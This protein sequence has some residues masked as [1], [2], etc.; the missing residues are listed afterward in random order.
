VEQIKQILTKYQQDRRILQIN[1]L[2]DEK[3]GVQVGGLVGAQT[4]FI[5][6]ASFTSSPRNYLIIDLDKEEAIYKENDLENILE[7]KDIVFFPDSFKNPMRFDLIEHN[8]VLQRT[9]AINKLSSNR[10]KGEIL[11]TYPEALFEKVVAPKVLD[12]MRIEITVG[13]KLDVNFLIEVLV[14][15]RFSRN[16]FVYE[17]GQF[18]IRGGIID[19]YSY[20]NELPYRV[21][22]FDDEVESIRT[23]DPATQLSDK[24]ISKISIVPNI[25]TRFEQAQKVSLFKVLPENTIIWVE[26]FQLLIDRLQSCFEKA[27]EYAN[28]L[29]KLDES[30]TALI[31]RDR[32]FNYPADII[33]EICSFPMVFL[34]NTATAK[35]IKETIKFSGKPQPSFNKNFNLLLENLSENT[36]NLFTNYIFMD[37][38]TQIERFYAKHLPLSREMAMNLQSFGKD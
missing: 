30:E 16:D 21:E 13:E 19:I 26:D 7:K 1:K 25:N 9:E 24:K 3:S 15:Y 6:G 36:S 8:N 28:S 35:N 18:S 37:S 14:D 10:S 29:S 20:G 23:F 4:A 34:G 11:V 32:A 22:L 5:I 38:V 17:P 31:F 27:N 33:E 12:Q 2:L